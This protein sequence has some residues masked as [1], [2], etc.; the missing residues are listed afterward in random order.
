MSSSGIVF[1]L[2]KLEEII[3]R[4]GALL[5][6]PKSAASTV[7]LVCEYFLRDYGSPHVSIYSTVSGVDLLHMS[8]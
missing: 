7:L 6:F 3:S 4:F 2:C 5:I 1:V 8:V